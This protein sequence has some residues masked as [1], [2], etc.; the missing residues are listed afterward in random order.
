VTCS[1]L[2][3][4]GAAAAFAGSIVFC[5]A[6][7][8]L[9]GG[10]LGA[11]GGPI[12]TSAYHL[13]L[14]QGPILASSRV[15]AMG[16]AY[17][18]LAEGAE[19]IPFNAAAASQR[20]PYSTSRTDYDLTASLTFP[21]SV[22]RTDFDNNGHVGFGYRNFV[23]ATLG[24]LLQ[25][26]HFGIGSVISLQN[27]SLGTPPQFT[28]VDSGVK[29][30]TV[31][32]FK[33]DA[34][35]SYGFLDD[36]LNV[37]GGLRGAIFNAVDTSTGDKLLLGTYG[38]G[39]QGG[40]L[41][42]P[43]ALPL[44]LGATV[45]SPVI[46]S[47]DAA[48]HVTTDLTSGDRRIGKFYLP[49][50]VDLPWEVEWGVAAQIGRR[51]LNLPWT[52]EDTLVGPEVEAERRIDPGSRTEEPHLEPRYQ[53]AHRLLRRRYRA[54]PRDKLLVSLSMLYAGRTPGAVGVESM[55]TQT[56]DRSGE[57]PSLTMRGGAEMEVLPNR[58]Q[59]RVGSYLEPTRFRESTSRV[60]G[61]TGFE[62][63]LLEWSVFGLFPEDN[64][65][66]VSGAVDAARE[67]FGWSL[68]FGSWY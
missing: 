52:D 11:Q 15:T 51:P 41:W 16:G 20:Y 64:V 25:R 63:K 17:S 5:G 22:D 18:A 26:D 67:Y 13:D 32:I 44:R 55:L 6:R 45:R 65:F 37:G 56:V 29:D 48:P 66:R 12:Q 3:A 46:G 23:F 8:A 35:V 36:E 33:I 1:K 28:A 9:A 58:F 43:K 2:R 21:T 61:T 14:F 39:L 19:G 38:A 30:L 57:K 60:H 49:Q 40:V 59:L 27:Y 24:G 7:P 54:T 31:R 68:G 34:V 42:R 62:V 47:I 53:A 4:L 10:A 50:G